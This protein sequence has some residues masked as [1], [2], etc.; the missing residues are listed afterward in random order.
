MNWPERFRNLAD[1]EPAEAIALLRE[2]APD[3][4]LALTIDESVERVLLGLAS[5]GA[6]TLT[7]TYGGQFIPDTARASDR[8]QRRG[9][10]LRPGGSLGRATAHPCRPHGDALQPGPDERGPVSRR[11]D[12]HR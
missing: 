11:G 10:G 1:L 8:T 6:A 9:G 7:Y 12:A 5:G 2:F 4:F 3:L